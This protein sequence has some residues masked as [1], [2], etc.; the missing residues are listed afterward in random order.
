MEQN[1][2][3]TEERMEA[4]LEK[5]NSLFMQ[6]MENGEYK[7]LIKTF[8]ENGKYSLVNI[9]YMKS[10][11][12]DFKVA[13]NMTEW[14]RLGRN[15]LP[16]SSNMKIIMPT[17]E[18]HEIEKKDKDG[19]PYKKEISKVNGF[20]ESFVFDISYTSGQEYSPYKLTEKITERDKKIFLQGIS[21]AL[22]TKQYKFKFADKEKFAADEICRIDPNNKTIELKKGLKDFEMILGLLDASSRVLSQ[23][24]KNDKFLGLSGEAAL[25]IEVSSMQY[26]LASHYGLDT[27]EYNFPQVKEMDSKDMLAFRDNVGIICSA[28]K[29][30]MD[31]IDYAFYKTS[32][33]EAENR[34]EVVTIKTPFRP[35][36]NSKPAEA[37]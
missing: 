31:K 36:Q 14:N 7:E 34:K 27:S 24:S 25:N 37:Y 35:S 16:N 1:N 3:I 8:G 11:K 15:I 13:K 20:H 32:Q 12:S 18:K 23:T 2:I 4:I 30:L 17:K 28:T 5:N 10:Q 19:N 6:I 21:E 33:Q 29:T 26:I 9:L 22:N